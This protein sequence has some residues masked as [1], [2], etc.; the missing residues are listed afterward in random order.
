MLKAI[1]RLVN[2]ESCFHDA[3]AYTT[4]NVIAAH[5]TFKLGATSGFSFIRADFIPFTSNIPTVL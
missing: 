1:H 5:L 3:Y 4:N 2:S